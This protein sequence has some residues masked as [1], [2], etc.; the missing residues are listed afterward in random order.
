L[1]L[2]I[3][4]FFKIKDLNRILSFMVKDK[5]NNTDLINLVLLK[6]ISFPIIDKEYSKKSLG[7]FLKN[8]L[9]N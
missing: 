6:K 1:S 4:N 2:N 8:Q 3:D 7:I 9:G 5:K